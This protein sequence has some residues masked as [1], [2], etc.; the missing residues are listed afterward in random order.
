MND[1]VLERILVLIDSLPYAPLLLTIGS[2]L[3][4]VESI[5]EPTTISTYT[6]LAGQARQKQCVCTTSRTSRFLRRLLLK[7]WPSLCMFL[8]K[9]LFSSSPL[10]TPPHVSPLLFAPIFFAQYFLF[11]FLTFMIMQ[12]P[13]G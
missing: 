8:F 4:K 3:A 7:L 13:A 11:L 2:R 12:N 10:P 9:P 5:R 6:M 1:N